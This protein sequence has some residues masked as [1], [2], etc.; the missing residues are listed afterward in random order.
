MISN[1]KFIQLK[2]QIVNIN[3]I[4]KVDQ[5]RSASGVDWYIRTVLDTATTQEPYIQSFYTSEQEAR[6]AYTKIMEQLCN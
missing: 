5:P 1:S 3:S 6:T 2:D 4:V